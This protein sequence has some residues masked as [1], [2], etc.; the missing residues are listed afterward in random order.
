MFKNVFQQ[1]VQDFKDAVTENL[2]ENGVKVAT[3]IGEVALLGFAAALLIK[4]IPTRTNTHIYL[5]I[6]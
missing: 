3:A 4:V 5:H 2:G 6:V 1:T